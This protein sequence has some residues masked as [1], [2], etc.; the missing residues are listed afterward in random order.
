MKIIE[1][2]VA[3]KR[4]DFNGNLFTRFLCTNQLA[5]GSEINV[6]VQTRSWNRERIISYDP[7]IMF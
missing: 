4:F 3:F 6:K 2:G 5:H 7:S 1:D